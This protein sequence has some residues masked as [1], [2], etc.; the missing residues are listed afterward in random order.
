MGNDT[1]QSTL[2]YLNIASILSLSSCTINVHTVLPFQLSRVILKFMGAPTKV[3]EYFLQMDKKRS[4]FIVNSFDHIQEKGHGRNVMMGFSV[5]VTALPFCHPLPLSLTVSVFLFS[6]LFP[7]PM[8]CIL[9]PDY[10]IDS[11]GYIC[12]GFGSSQYLSMDPALQR[13]A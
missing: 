3:N 13:P 6:S 1:D 9:V 11:I 12:I 7:F 10:P 5:P 8:L 4:I 2:T